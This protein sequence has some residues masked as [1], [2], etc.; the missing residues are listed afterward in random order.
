MMKEEDGEKV[1]L[2]QLALG[3]LELR[4]RPLRHEHG[5]AAA[6][7]SLQQHDKGQ[8]RD[9]QLLIGQSR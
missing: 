8:A 6:A 4:L 3:R 2:K 7:Q 9:Q 1:E 5:V